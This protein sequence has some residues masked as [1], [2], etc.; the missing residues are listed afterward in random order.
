[1]TRTII[2]FSTALLL[3][4]PI[5]AS[6]HRFSVHDLNHDGYLDRYE[7]EQFQLHRAEHQKPYK[8]PSNS[9]SFEDIDENYDGLVTEEELIQKLNNQ[10]RQQRRLRKR[11]QSW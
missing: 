2:T 10:L 9:M 11:E 5:N 6:E 3:I 7:F 1:M 8:Q 4:S